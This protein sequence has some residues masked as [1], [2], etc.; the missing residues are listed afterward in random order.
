MF[1]SNVPLFA[2]PIEGMIWAFGWTIII[3]VIWHLRGRRKDKKL[4]LIHKERLAAMEKG[5]PLPELPEYEESSRPGL[6]EL[7]AAG[8][9]NPRWP[10]GVAV[11]LVTGGAGTTLAMY[12]SGDPFHRQVWPFGM[13]P[14]FLGLG[15]VLFYG[16]M[17]RGTK[18]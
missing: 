18:S 4:E 9:V 15:F 8:R 7:L 14:I 3:V 5:I 10:L 1:A 6:V 2:G 16:V 13:I 11:L 17:H 12:L